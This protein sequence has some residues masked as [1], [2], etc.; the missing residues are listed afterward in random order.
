[1]S[2]NPSLEAKV[3]ALSQL[4]KEEFIPSLRRLDDKLDIIDRLQGRM[5]GDIATLYRRTA[6]D[7][8][9][10][11][12]IDGVIEEAQERRTR[13]A[14]GRRDVRNIV[15]GAI[16][17]ILFAGIAFLIGYYLKGGK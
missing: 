14:D 15:V 16:V 10:Q 17:N 13:G 11:G 4:L 3:E 1:M 7:G 9:I 2:P 8:P 6:D 5:E 12:R